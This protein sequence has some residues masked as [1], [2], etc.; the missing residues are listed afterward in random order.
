M[1]HVAVCLPQQAV[2]LSQSLPPHWM[3]HTGKNQSPFFEVLQLLCYRHS[4]GHGFVEE[5][6]HP[7]VKIVKVESGMSSELYLLVLQSHL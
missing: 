6:I 4:L 2:L 7:S 3:P 1:V 5:E